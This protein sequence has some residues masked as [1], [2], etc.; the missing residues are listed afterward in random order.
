M[1]KLLAICLSVLLICAAMPFAF[2][3]ASEEPTI[4]VSDVEGKAGDTVSVTVS[5]KNNP[6]VVSALIKVGYDASALELLDAAEGDFNISGYKFGPLTKNPFTINFCDATAEENYTEELFATLTF[7]IKDDAAAGEYPVTLTYSCEDD[8]YGAGIDMPMVE[9][10]ADEGSVTVVADPEPEPDPEVEGNIIANGTFNEG[11]AGWSASGECVLEHDNGALHVYMNDD[12]SFINAGTYTLKANTEYKLTFKAKSI[13]GGTITPKMNKADWS[14]TVVE[15]KMTFTEEWADYEWT[16]TTTDVTS[17]MLFFQSGHPASAKQEVWLDQVVLVEVAQPEPPAEPSF[18]GYI[19]N[20]DFETGDLTSWINLWDGCTITFVEGYESNHAVEIV[21][22]K[23]WSHTR[24]NLIPVEANTTYRLSAYVKNAQDMAFV[25]KEGN[26]SFD[27]TPSEI[28]AFPAGDEWQLFTMEFNTGV[29]KNGSAVTIDSI[30]VLVIGYGENGGSVVIDNITLEKVEE[31]EP[32]AEPSFDG[33][34]TNGDFE[35]GDLTAWREDYPSSI[36]DAV[37]HG[38]KYSVSSSNT[39]K[40]YDLLARQDGIAVEPGANYILTFWYY[41]DGSNADPSFYAYIKNDEGNVKSVTT[42][43]G[44]PNTWGKVELEFNAGENSEIYVLLQN[45]TVDDGG[46]YYFDDVSIA[47]LKE[48]SFDGYM[49]N[50]DFETGNLN[51]WTNLWNGCTYEF[52]EGYESDTAISITAGSWSQIRQDGIAVEPNTDYVLSAWVKNA[53]NFGLIIKAGDDSGDINSTYIESC[54]DW[55]EYT[56]KFNSG[57]QTAICALLIGW[58]GGGSA[59]VDNVS[60]AVDEGGDD[61]IDPP[62]FTEP[63]I[64]LPI[65]EAAPGDTITVPVLFKNNP[66]LVSALVKVGYDS[67][68]LELLSATEGDFNVAGYKFGPLT[69]NPFTINFCDATASNYTAELFATLTFKVKEDAVGG[70]YALTLTFDCEGDF[71]GEGIEMPT[72]YFEGQEGSVTVL[73]CAHEYDGAC[74]P[75]CNLCGAIRDVHVGLVH[76]DAVEPGCHYIGNIEYWFCPDCECVWQDEALTQLTNLKNVVLP[77]KGGDVVHFE[78]IEPGCHY[79]GQIEHWYCPECDQFWADEALTQLTNSK[80]VVLPYVGSENLQH[81]EAKDP[82]CSE[83]GNIEYWF[84]PDCEQYWQDEAL[85]QLTNVKNVQIAPIDHTIVHFDAVEPGCHYIGNIEYWFCSVCEGFWQDEALTQ[86]TNSKNIIVPAKGG[87]VVHFE[88]IE[89]GC[90][91]NGQIEHWYCPEC[92][93]F[94]AD[95]ALTQLTNSKNVVLPATGSDKLQ[96]VEA[97]DAT[98]TENGNIEYWYCS[99]CEQYWADEA[100]TQLTNSKNVIIP[101]TGSV[102]PDS[103]ITGDSVVPVVVALLTLIASGVAVS[104][105]KN[106]KRA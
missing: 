65:I 20:G 46:T 15:Q 103:P 28:G 52:V 97:K 1:K 14:G 34:I 106:K 80:N 37:A 55:T 27:L 23:Q 17:Y 16:F 56:V 98:A 50:G 96:H 11:I 76:F 22:N 32:P 41:Y 64:V 26:D 44:A 102:D 73:A 2:A 77:A 47:K 12:W 60:L 40:K 89:P 51:S 99:E 59:I 105:L 95:E 24:Q 42:H 29:D 88:A 33:Y 58:D 84:C 5:L 75:D 3:T 93:Q 48:P 25:I 83:G 100:L 78:A 71:Y 6:G 68:V 43:V 9:F 81:V 30:C 10:G 49:T 69:K 92:D 45:R 61:P 101:A 21:A 13:N 4:V 38:G 57:D 90:H 104:V 86:V 35:T 85:T 19:T 70:T 54:G 7:K 79:N 82:T 36:S 18:D 62:V 53:N 31:P 66:G 91:Y 87:D 63:T 72:V 8:F 39:Y 74:D 67:S 94:W